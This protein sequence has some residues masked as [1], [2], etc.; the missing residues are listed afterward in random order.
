MYWHGD[1]NYRA[2]PEVCQLAD[3]DDNAALANSPDRRAGGNPKPV[4][5]RDRSRFGL[6]VSGL[7]VS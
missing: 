6:Q 5:V 2:M 4:D 3:T 7:Q 1:C